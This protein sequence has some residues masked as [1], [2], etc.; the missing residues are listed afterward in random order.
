ML[1]KLLLSLL[2]FSLISTS[3]FSVISCVTQNDKI[4]NNII[5]KINATDH[6]EVYTKNISGDLKDKDTIFAIKNAMLLNLSQMSYVNI[7][8]IENKNLASNTSID[9]KISVKIYSKQEIFIKSV[10]WYNNDTKNNFATIMTGIYTIRNHALY[11]TTN[12]GLYSSNNGFVFNRIINDTLNN[13]IIY[14]VYQTLAGQIYIGTSIGLFVSNNLIN[15]VRLEVVKPVYQIIQYI[16]GVIYLN[17][18]LNGILYSENNGISFK[19][20]D[21]LIFTKAN[22]LQIH[23]GIMYACTNQGIFY[24]ENNNFI[25]EQYLNSVINVNLIYWLNDNKELIGTQNGLWYY[26]HVFNDIYILKQVGMNLENFSS[27]S[28]YSVIR[29]KNV[30]SYL[31]ISTNKGIFYSKNTNDFYP[32]VE[33]NYLAYSPIYSYFPYT[34]LLLNNSNDNLLNKSLLTFYQVDLS[35]FLS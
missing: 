13:C 15:F 23:K 32:I 34:I 18:G 6:V 25:Q 26:N 12:D 33:E 8:G 24:L 2:T 5:K 21:N 14:D 30:N 17:L 11:L 22:Y 7:Q 4:F 3:S 29:V 10:I 19:Q 27:A 9:I 1:K 20:I 16:N 28:I 35:M 31:Y